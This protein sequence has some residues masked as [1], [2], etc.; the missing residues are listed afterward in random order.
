[1]AAFHKEYAVEGITKSDCDRVNSSALRQYNKALHQLQKYLSSNELLDKRT[2]LMCCRLFYCIEIARQDYATALRHLKSGL[3]ILKEWKD[4]AKSELTSNMNSSPTDYANELI[5]VFCRL[6]V[7][8]R[9]LE[10]GQPP[11]LVLTTPE[12]RS[13]L[14]PCVPVTF[15]SLADAWISMNKL[16]N[17]AFQFLALR[18]EHGRGLLKD[19]KIGN[20]GERYILER[21]IDRWMIAFKAFMERANSNLSSLDSDSAAMCAFIHRG[22]KLLVHL[23]SRQDSFDLYDDFNN[24]LNKAEKIITNQDADS[25]T[26]P[27]GFAF[28]T[29][30][31]AILWLL[32]INCPDSAMRA[33]IIW[34]M[35][36]WPRREGVWDGKQ[37]SGAPEQ[38]QES[39]QQSQSRDDFTIL[40]LGSSAERAGKEKGEF[41]LHGFSK[42][43]GVLDGKQSSIVKVFK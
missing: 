17:W 8:V 30:L 13:G 29:G 35:K 2:V 36:M 4:S 19:I 11:Y 14:V 16:M 37:S 6:D 27:R 28:E 3:I 33:R 34:L 20:L 1:L 43:L 25:K 12:E 24:V 26:P 41:Y 5:E 42:I 38:G 40:R 18:M 10:N 31:V 39:V 22:T 15:Y 9:I 7:Q 23:A 32:A 21:E